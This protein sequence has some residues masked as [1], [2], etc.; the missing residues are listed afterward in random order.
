MSEANYRTVECCKNCK[1]WD[2]GF[3][4][5]KSTCIKYIFESYL[6]DSIC[7]NYK[8]RFLNE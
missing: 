2:D 5:Y 4:D 6:S 3:G 8:S 1:W 7:D